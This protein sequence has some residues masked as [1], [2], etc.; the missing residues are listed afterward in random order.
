M[1]YFIA[2]Y[3]NSPS[4]PSEKFKSFLNELRNAPNQT[5]DLEAFDEPLSYDQA[6]EVAEL[7]FDTLESNPESCSEPH[8]F[9]GF[10]H[11]RVASLRNFTFVIEI[12][13][14]RVF[15]FDF[16]PPN[17]PSSGPFVDDTVPVFV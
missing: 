9:N 7:I 12:I 5:I 6:V 10:S 17:V 2:F 8:P 16:I 14:N 11:F 3:V 4:K 1:A 15:I 13:E